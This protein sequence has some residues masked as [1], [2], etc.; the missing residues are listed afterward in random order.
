MSSTGSRAILQCPAGHYFFSTAIIDGVHSTQS[1]LYGNHFGTHAV[2][3]QR[4][5]SQCSYTQP[6]SGRHPD[7]VTQWV[8]GRH[9]A[10]L[11]HCKTFSVL[12]MV[13]SMSLSSELSHTHI[14][15]VFSAKA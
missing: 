5:A 4:K 12:S 3:L 15:L 9:H 6:T 8:P 7:L 11:H 1:M 10:I 2:T 14:S 13:P